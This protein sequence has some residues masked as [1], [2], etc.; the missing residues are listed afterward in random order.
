ARAT[1]G[2]S[3]GVGVIVASTRCAVARARN[4]AA[5]ATTTPWI[6]PR[7]LRRKTSIWFGCQQCPGHRPD[8]LCAKKRER[9]HR[10]LQRRELAK[11]SPPRP[12]RRHLGPTWRRA[13][14][15]SLID[16]LGRRLR[17]AEALFHVDGRGRPGIKA[18]G[19]TYRGRRMEPVLF[20]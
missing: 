12:L 15:D 16:R 11:M 6:S 19:R 10:L 4:P 14:P 7:C 5:A 8:L 18:S 13:R 1:A 3:A 9:L 20:V 17:G 2:W